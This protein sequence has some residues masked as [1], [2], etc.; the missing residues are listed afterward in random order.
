MTELTERFRTLQDEYRAFYEIRNH[1]KPGVEYE[2]WKRR[3]SAGE[4]RVWAGRL[5]EQANRVFPLIAELK[6]DLKHERPY[7]ELQSFFR[8]DVRDLEQELEKYGFR[9]QHPEVN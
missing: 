8:E 2:D 1:P 6:G 9:P 7:H 3:L 4:K 5:T